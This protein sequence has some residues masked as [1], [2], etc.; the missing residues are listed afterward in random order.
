MRRRTC[1]FVYSILILC[2]F[3]IPSKCRAQCRDDEILVG[4]DTKFYYCQLISSPSDVRRVMN[5]AGSL[6]PEMYGRE[7]K[8][9]KAVIDVARCLTKD[10]GTPFKWGGR[11][12]FPEEC[13]QGSGQ[14]LDCSGV[15]AFAMQ[16][17]ACFVSGYYRAAFNLLRALS[18]SSAADQAEYFKQHKAWSSSKSEPLPGD[19]IFFKETYKDCKG[20]CHV[21]IFLG[22]AKDGNGKRFIFEAS[23]TRGV[24]VTTM[25]DKWRSKI[26]GYGN[27]SLLYLRISGQD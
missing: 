23:S 9:R 3:L 6:Q 19:A 20:I 10:P 12:S 4:E 14:G 15:E 27:A 5:E 13:V 2:L 11:Y 8:Y 16:F 22:D 17:A 21:A 1:F 18:D 24:V 25:P 7:W 26:V